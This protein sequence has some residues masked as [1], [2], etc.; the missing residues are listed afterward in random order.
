MERYNYEYAEANELTTL[1]GDVTEHQAKQHDELDEPPEHVHAY[2]LFFFRVL[3]K[4]P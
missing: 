3:K 4:L 1:D 2:G